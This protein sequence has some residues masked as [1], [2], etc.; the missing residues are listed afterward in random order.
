MTRTSRAPGRRTAVALTLLCALTATAQ[1]PAARAVP[2]P[3]P[4][5]L[6]DVRRQLDDLYHQSEVATEKYNAADEKAKAQQKQVTLLNGKVKAAE[7]KEARLRELLGAAARAQYRGGGLPAEVQFAFASDPERALDDAAVVRQAQQGTRQK[8]AA[9]EAARA[10]LRT[11]TDEATAELA[12]LKSTRRAMARH[13]EKIKARIATARAL[14]SGLQAEELRR[15]AALERQ[16]EAESQAEWVGTGI[17]DQVGTQATEAGRAA[18]EYA[19]EQLGKPYVWGAEG[20]DSFDCSGLTSQAWLHAGLVIPRTAEQQW[21]QLPHVPI[22][23]MRPGD[24]I[25]YYADASHVAIYIG[26]GKIIQAP[27]PGRWVYVS[28]AGSMEI[29]GVVRPDA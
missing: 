16:Q 10:E 19:T 4:A 18:I 14:E 17:L 13:R 2:A 22:S 20:P 12:E 8:L 5:T 27:R 21:A 24:L 15:L 29:L 3:R 25:I 7:E 9:L 23:Q 11:R 28:P 26:D 6:E 1:A